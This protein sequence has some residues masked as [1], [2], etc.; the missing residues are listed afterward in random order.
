MTAHVVDIVTP[1][2]FKLYGLWYGP[3]KPKRVAIFIHGLTSSVFGGIQRKVAPLLSDGKTA[4][5]TFNNR[6]F[7]LVNR[8]GGNR[9]I[10][11][12]AA[13]EIF[14]D[15]IDDIQGAVDLAKKSGAK[16]IYLAGHSTG[17]QKSVFY[18]SGKRADKRVKGIILIAPVSDYAAAIKRH[19]KKVARAMRYA[20]ALI[21]KGKPHELLPLSLWSEELDDAQRFE[22]LYSPDSIEEI[23]CYAQNGKRPKIL[24]NVRVPVLVLWAGKDEFADRPGKE[25]LAWFDKMILS[26]HRVQSVVGA[27]HS[28][29]GKEKMLLDAIRSWMM[30][31]GR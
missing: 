1:K 2:K 29:K 14:K 25:I 18:A 3:K 23:F 7:G 15:C 22:S 16:D 27:E 13:H 20:K 11:A 10:I 17:C 9:P 30:T 19:G 4:V 24:Q 28:F 21:K 31:V 12:G 6:G 26:P 8:I 5:L